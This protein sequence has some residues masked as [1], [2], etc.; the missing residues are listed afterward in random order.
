[1]SVAVVLFVYLSDNVN[2]SARLLTRSHKIPPS[3][4]HCIIV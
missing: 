2:K 3:V 1:M 4:Q